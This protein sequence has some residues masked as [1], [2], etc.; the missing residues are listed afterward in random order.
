APR[1]ARCAP[2]SAG[3]LHQARGIDAPR[4]ALAIEDR[5]FRRGEDRLHPA[6]ATA[7]ATASAR[8]WV[9]VT[10][11]CEMPPASARTFALPARTT[12][13]APLGCRLTLMSCHRLPR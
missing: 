3:P 12:D 11:T 7:N 6:T 2:L 9:K 10:R 8:S 13:G 1:V 4:L 5:G